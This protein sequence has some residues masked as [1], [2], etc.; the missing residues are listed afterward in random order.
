MK[1]GDQPPKQF[2]LIRQSGDTPDPALTAMG[3]IAVSQ[4]TGAPA[5]SLLAVVAMLLTGLAGPDASIR[6]SLGP[7]RLAKLDLLTSAED[8]R[9]QR[10]INRFTCPLETMQRRLGEKMGRYSPNALELTA[11]GAH[12]SST[13]I[14]LA[15][16]EL[17]DKSLRRHM[18]T[19]TAATQ[20]GPS[21]TLL[22]DLADDPV[23]PRMEA[24]LH[25]QFLVKGA[26]GLS[27]DS[28]VE[29]CHLRTAL[30]VHPKLDLARKGPGPSKVMKVLTNLLDGVTVTKRP[31]SIERGRDSSLLARAHAML[32][33]TKAEI[34]AMHAMDS[35]HLHRFLWL[36]EGDCSDALKPGDGTACE[37]FLAAYQGAIQEILGFRRE[38]RGLM[39]DFES[40][41]MAAKFESELHTYEDEIQQTAAS[42]GPWARGLPQTLFWALGFLRRSMPADRR[43]D[44]EGLMAAAFAA[45]RRLVENHRH[46]VLVITNASLLADRIWLAGRIVEEL[47]KGIP[48]KFHI[49]VRSF[50]QQEKSRFDPVIDA[51]LDTG[52]LVRNEDKRLTL[53]PVDLT[54]VQE[55]LV[56]RFLEM[57]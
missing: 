19:F 43:P 45:A 47:E 6:D 3:L 14:K 41:K 1:S 56:K 50:D 51:L 54:D 7:C 18:D 11:N 35:D 52:V 40:R 8:F 49:L 30:V 23:P 13:T 2:P 39:M 16:Q 20:P 9:L 42:A 46:Q 5:D 57:P 4:T 37:T 31:D 24:V 22:Q 15:D 17:Q 12:S 26:D 21:N 32:A 29:K 28:L 55:E 48:L 44:D 25:P 34:E 53:G 38:G 33:L 36:K 10:S 27:L